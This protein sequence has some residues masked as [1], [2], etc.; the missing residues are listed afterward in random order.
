MNL[1]PPGVVITA[2]SQG[3]VRPQPLRGGLKWIIPILEE[4]QVYP[5]HW[6][7]YT[8]SGKPAEG[9]KAGDDSI[10]ARTKDGQEV[11]LDSSIIFRL[12]VNQVVRVHIDWQDRYVEEFIRP[13]MRG[14][15]RSEVSQ[16]TVDEVNSS[17]RKDLEATLDRI[18]KEELL[19]KGIILDRFPTP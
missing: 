19:D 9:E 11:R 3:G 18:L 13:L 8:M 10:R 1:K 14:I 16:F 17:A 4:V 6:Q 2:V 5:I 12:D 15:L 7:T